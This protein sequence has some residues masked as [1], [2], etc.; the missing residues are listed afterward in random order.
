V[1]A[2]ENSQNLPAR[3]SAAHAHLLE[4][5][6]LAYSFRVIISDMYGSAKN[7]IQLSPLREISRDVFRRLAIFTCWRDLHLVSAELV[8]TSC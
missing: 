5:L 1:D 2:A 4:Q 7:S 6:M 3:S 8:K